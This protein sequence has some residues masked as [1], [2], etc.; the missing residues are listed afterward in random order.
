M[1][2]AHRLLR[3]GR[4]GLLLAALA[5]PAAGC[6][7]PTD[8]AASRPPGGPAA[9]G[10][11]AL[12]FPVEV[13]PVSP[14]VVEYAVNA[15]G[16]IEAF[17]TVQATA[18][19]PGV[20]EKVRF[21]EGEKVAAGAILVE[22]EPQ[23]YKLAVDSARAALEKSDA[24]TADAQAGLDRREKAVAATPGLIP[25]EEIASWRT[26]LLTAQADVAEKKAAL[27]QAELNLR[28]A[29]VRAPVPGIIET[30]RVQ[31]G[32]Y[33]QPGTVLATL[34]QREPLLLRFNVAATEAA[35]LR[36]RQTCRFR[37]RSDNRTYT[38]TITHVGHAADP[39]SRMVTVTAEVT[40]GDRAGL[41]PGA[42]VEVVV[43]IGGARASP[44]LPQ[45]AVR[46]TE[47]GFVAYVIEGNVAR[48]RVLTLGLRTPDGAVEVKTGVRPGELVVVRGA[49]ALR[50]NAVVEVEKK[51]QASRPPV[52]ESLMP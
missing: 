11:R 15:V 22:I 51:T 49:E 7:K 19:L 24:A 38:A 47:R 20:V 43:P 16:S 9:G 29:Y 32:Q 42:F 28:E 17:E 10:R 26:R 50:D 40:G 21:R 33:A 5:L 3:V 35:E 14:R 2:R 48:E 13:Q 27:A 30:R 4:T 31:T 6:R 23:R 45:T 52:G 41:R 18:R 12:R 37:L 44:V 46:P 1:K 25:A 8:A 39:A 34:V 36:P